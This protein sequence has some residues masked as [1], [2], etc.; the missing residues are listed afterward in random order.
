MLLKR[1]AVGGM[2]ELFLA[3]DET[4]G[5]QVVIKRILPYLSHEP[6]FVQMF[7]DEAR[8]AA[9]LHHQNII[10]VHELGKLQDSMFIAMEFVDGIDLRKIFQEEA[11]LG[12]TVPYGVAALVTARV[13][14]GLYYAHNATG[15][16]GRKLGVIHRDISP[17]NVMVGF[18]GR[19][20]L[21]DFG[22]SKATAVMERSK[23][24]VIKGK[25][26]YLSPEQLTQERIDHRA[27]L[28]ALGSMLYELTCG[29]SPFY[30]PSTEAVIYAIRSEDPQPPAV[31][32]SDYPPELSRIVMKCL[33]KDR[34]R[35]YQQADEIAHDLEVFL[36]TTLP[37]GEEELR[38]YVERLFGSEEDATRMAV[39][40]HKPPTPPARKS[41]LAAISKPPSGPKSSPGDPVRPAPALSRKPTITGGKQM[42]DP[43]TGAATKL[44]SPGEVG[45]AMAPAAPPM[46]KPSGARYQ[47][48]GSSGPEPSVTHETRPGS[49][50]PSPPPMEDDDPELTLPPN[51][52]QIAEL[53]RYAPVEDGDEDEST[54]PLQAAASRP[55]QGSLPP[56]PARRLGI[57]P[58]LFDLAGP[59][60]ELAG[61][62]V[63]SEP[64]LT[65]MT[66][67]PHFEEDE[68]E[69]ATLFDAPRSGPRR[70]G[71]GPPP[72][73]VRDGAVGPGRLVVAAVLGLLLV[74]AG[75]VAW[76]AWAGPPASPPPAQA[77]TGGEPPESMETVLLD[78]PPETA[79]PARPR[80]VLSTQR[81]TLVFDGP[82][83]ATVSRN[84]ESV[85]LGV[86][87]EAEPGL[88]EYE[89][90]CPGTQATRQGAIQLDA[91][92][93][94]TPVHIPLTHCRR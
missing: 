41:S 39:E 79:P 35:R 92:A 31:L 88:V 71:S 85:E 38:E 46:R 52:R 60:Q 56:P 87:V 65:P 14:G 40:T 93:I 78:A 69:H 20:K 73:A 13:C 29:K 37:T 49:L 7:L 91:S 81:L 54:V 90:R 86:A 22:I 28:F 6:E 25:F 82:R 75:A 66:N 61:P 10:Q 44:A 12:F 76:L 3:R 21:V 64:S 5:A 45:R 27:D 83:G 57:D 51:L 63:P 77:Q 9:Q 16:D 68:P 80:R 32:R 11:K 55:R 2:A 43:G 89:Y 67:A 48:A 30:K 58:P 8:I 18:D 19:V 15:V 26:L 36:A 59:V 23:P 34:T 24:G 74:A 70:L 1:L 17:Q 50:H 84:G 94:G 62:P 72:A 4:T 53:P 33:A 42:V 47:S